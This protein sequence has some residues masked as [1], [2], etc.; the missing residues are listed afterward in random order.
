[1]SSRHPRRFQLGRDGDENGV[2]YNHASSNE[3]GDLT[4]GRP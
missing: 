1:M 2:A 3:S 4:H